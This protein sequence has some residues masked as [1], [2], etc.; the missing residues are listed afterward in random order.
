LDLCLERAE[1]FPEF[2]SRVEL[3]EEDRAVIH[4]FNFWYSGKEFEYL[5]K[6]SARPPF[7]SLVAET[8]LRLLG[9]TKSLARDAAL[10]GS[11]NKGPA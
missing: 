7:L 11:T 1:S 2:R 3:A 10:R 8:C 5:R 9:Q 6:G 4:L